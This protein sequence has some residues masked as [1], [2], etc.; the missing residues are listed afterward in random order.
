M[1][2][3]NPPPNTN[4]NQADHLLQPPGWH[5]QKVQKRRA[6]NTIYQI[7]PSLHLMSVRTENHITGTVILIIP[8]NFPPASSNLLATSASATIIPDTPMNVPIKNIVVLVAFMNKEVMEEFVEIRVV[9]LII[10]AEV[11]STV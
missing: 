3:L 11:T 5:N 2:V 9:R 1:E 7:S 4:S 10:E 6:D 8:N